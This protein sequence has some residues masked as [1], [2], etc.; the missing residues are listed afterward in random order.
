MCGSNYTLDCH[1]SFKRNG[2]CYRWLC[3]YVHLPPL[4]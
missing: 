1:L 3:C 4:H 2:G